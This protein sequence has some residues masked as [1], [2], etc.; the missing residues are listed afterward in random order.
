MAALSAL[1]DVLDKNFVH[2]FLLVQKSNY[3][4]LDTK[5]KTRYPN[6]KGCLVYKALKGF[7]NTKVPRK[8]CQLW[9]EYCSI[10]QNEPPYQ[11]T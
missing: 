8:E 1:E 6:L 9:M 11:T 2:R 4:E 10:S 5:I 3:E 7:A